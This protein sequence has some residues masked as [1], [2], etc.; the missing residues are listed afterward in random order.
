MHVAER[1]TDFYRNNDRFRFINN[2][3]IVKFITICGLQRV[4]RCNLCHLNV[5]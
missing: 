5:R 1:A 4:V 3:Y 2:Y